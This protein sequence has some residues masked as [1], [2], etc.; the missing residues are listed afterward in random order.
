MKKAIIE[1]IFWIF[2]SVIFGIGVL[3][4]CG[5]TGGY[6]WFTTY[7]LE[8]MLSF[9]NLVVFF[10]IFTFFKVPKDIQHKCLFWGILGAVVFRFIFIIFGI[11]LL[12]WF[13][14]LIY[15]AGAY[16]IY[17]GVKM[18]FIDDDFEIENSKIYQFIVNKFKFNPSFVKDKFFHNGAPTKLLLVLLVIELTDI[19]FAFDSVPAALCVTNDLF[20]VF[21]S[22]LFAIMGLRAMYFVISEVIEKFWALQHAVSIILISI[23]LKIFLTNVYHISELYF[24]LF[25]IITIIL[26]GVISVLIPKDGE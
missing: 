6:Q 25:T 15:V 21:T 1:T 5:N 20:I 23:G 11:G 13:H 18:F 22:N 19:T 24:F 26:S 10:M 7:T 17:T 12:S 2:I 14:W 9:D 8:K 4:T 16:L 3:L